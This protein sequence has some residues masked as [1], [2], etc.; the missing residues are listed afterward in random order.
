LFRELKMIFTES[1][2]FGEVNMLWTSRVKGGG[3]SG[4]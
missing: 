4:G 1:H 3:G 2:L